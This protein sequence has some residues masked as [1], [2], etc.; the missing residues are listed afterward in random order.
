[1]LLAATGL[2]LMLLP[3]EPSVAMCSHPSFPQTPLDVY[4]VRTSPMVVV[5]Y[6]L[7]TTPPPDAHGNYSFYFQVN[8]SYAGQF[9]RRIEVTNYAHY[10]D[11]P[12]GYEVAGNSTSAH[13]TG[14]FLVDWG[15]QTAILFLQ[16]DTAA[17]RDTRKQYASEYAF[18]DCSYSTIGNNDSLRME[19]FLNALFN[20]PVPPSP[21]PDQSFTSPLQNPS[22]APSVSAP[23]ALPP[24]AKRISDSKRALATRAAA[25]A[26]IV[27]GVLALFKY[28]KS[29]LFQRWRA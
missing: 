21:P 7:G 24:T 25:L 9:P 20:M 1:M 28:P 4:R 27:G 19:R 26:V 2:S 5:G 15:G 29:P 18:S 16:K 3:I 23:E 11:L 6:I 17:G 12:S 8:R 13:N 22:T 14:R 10:Q